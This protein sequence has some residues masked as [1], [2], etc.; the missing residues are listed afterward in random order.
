MWEVSDGITDDCG[1]KFS[2]LQNITHCYKRSVYADWPYT[3]YTMAHARSK[4]DFAELLDRMR[5][6]IEFKSVRVLMT[7]KEFKKK[8]MVYFTEDYRNWQ[9]KYIPE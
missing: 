9:R 3:L 6:L 5:S 2:T 1:K 8:R 7:L 4:S